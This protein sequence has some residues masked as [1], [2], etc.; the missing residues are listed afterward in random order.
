MRPSGTVPPH[1]RRWFPPLQVTKAGNLFSQPLVD[2]DDGSQ[3]PDPQPLVG[4][5]AVPDAP[6]LGLNNVYG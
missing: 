2:R 1:P 3:T 5:M 4:D 6:T